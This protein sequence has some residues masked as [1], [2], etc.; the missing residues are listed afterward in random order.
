MLISSSLFFKCVCLPFFKTLFSTVFFFFLFFFS[1]KQLRWTP[2]VDDRQ[3]GPPDTGTAAG[4]TAGLRTE[5][6][7]AAGQAAVHL[8]TGR[9]RSVPD[10]I[11]PHGEADIAQRQLGRCHRPAQS[12]AIGTGNGWSSAECL[13]NNHVT[14]PPSH[15]TM[16]PAT[17]AMALAAATATPAPSHRRQRSVRRPWVC[18]FR[19]FLRDHRHLRHRHRQRAA[20][21]PRT[22]AIDRSRHHHRRP[23]R[24]SPPPA[25]RTLANPPDHRASS[26]RRWA[27]GR[28][29]RSPRIR[30]PRC[31]KRHDR[32][33]RMTSGSRSTGGRSSRT[34]GRNRF[35]GPFRP[36]TATPTEIWT[37]K[38]N[39][40]RSSLMIFNFSF[41][42]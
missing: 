17:A 2:A 29:L 33:R 6:D 25:A 9:H 20:Y 21:C 35:H 36:A 10:Q 1:L 24:P 27:C 16:A 18:R 12:V 8:H 22:V 15:R 31:A 13:Q 4:G 34:S 3:L 41:S 37:T 39:G 32:S 23:V 30:W 28:K 7:D 11:A 42:K 5:C 26:R 14:R 19:Y 38:V 40:T